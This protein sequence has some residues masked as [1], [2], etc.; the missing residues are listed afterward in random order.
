MARQFQARTEQNG[1][2]QFRPTA[3]LPKQPLK[4][5]V[6]AAQVLGMNCLVLSARYNKIAPT[7]YGMGAPPSAVHGQRWQESVVWRNFKELEGELFPADAD[8]F[9]AVFKP[10]SSRNI[11][12]LW[13]LGVVQ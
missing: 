1:F 5:F 12:I 13:P 3:H 7:K 4:A 10:D 6:S 11:V 9:D 8:R 2:V